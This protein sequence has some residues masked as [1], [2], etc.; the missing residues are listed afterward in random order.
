MKI[1]FLTWKDIKHPFAWWAE[2]VMFEYAKWLVERWHKVTWFWYAFKGGLDEEFVDGIQIIRKFSVYTGYLLFPRWYRKTFAWKYDIIIDEA[3][4]L[5]FL[6][7]LFEKT[8]PIF[9]FIHH[10]LDTERWHSFC[11]P[12][13]PVFRYL[14]RKIVKQYKNIP[15]ITVS[16]STK[17]ELVRD[18]GFAAQK[19]QVIESACDLQPIEAIDWDHKASTVTFLG[20]LM[21]IKRT[22]DAIKAFSLLVKKMP[23][24]TLQIIGNGQDKHYV[25]WLHKLVH[26]L[27]LEKS[28]Q[29][30]WYISR[31][32]LKNYLVPSTL[33]LVPSQKEWFGLVVLEANAYGLPAIWYNVP[34]LKESIKD[35]T[36][37]YLIPDGNRQAMGEKMI[38]ILDTTPW[39]KGL[40][41]STLSYIKTLD[42]WEQKVALFEKIICGKSLF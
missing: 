40:A 7:P 14:Y 30:L 41:Q 12:F 16:S 24:Y 18:F 25:S 32:D 10:V 23:Q 35:G 6:S 20:R 39:Y 26:Q 38:E 4:W 22:E 21:P 8:T 27:G 9:L 33:L 15:T 37:W 29:F 36:N 28:V 2:Q 19:I 42:S 31:N 3:G 5:P 17:E 11:F 34:W 1:L 13:S